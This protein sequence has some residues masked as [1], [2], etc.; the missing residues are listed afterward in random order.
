M[1]RMM[2]AIALGLQFP[3]HAQSTDDFETRTQKGRSANLSLPYRLFKPAG[4]ATSR[5]YPLVIALHGAGERGTNNTAQLTANALA[6]VWARDSNQAK[7]PAFVAAPQCPPNGMWA[8]NGRP[9]DGSQ[10]S[11]PAKVAL[12]MLDSL[13]KEF[14]LDSDRIYIT[15]L[16][17]GGFGTW[18][19]TM[20]NPGR[21]AAAVPICGAGDVTKADRIKS[22]P[23]WAFHGDK[24]PTVP[25]AGSRD[26]IAALKTAG[27]DP[28]YTEYP[29]VGHDS[30]T[31]A[32]R[33][34]DLVAWVMSQ[35]RG[36]AT[37]IIRSL[38]NSNPNGAY[39]IGELWR[40]DG[41]SLGTTR[42]APF[43]QDARTLH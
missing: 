34:P 22:L 20:R 32:L 37:G 28:K 25:V 27:G 35:R 36:M 5:K 43:K 17:L 11:D 33:E 12:E 23:I 13:A 42:R 40:I 26:M 21:F 31:P 3:T 16:S 24:D 8:P 9:I 15:G 6:T 38:S 39:S 19:L 2:A 30:W 10:P 41:R 29:G 14:P 1:L 18:D 7:F 4:Y